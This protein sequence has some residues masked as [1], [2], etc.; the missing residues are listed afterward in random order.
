MDTLNK[1]LKYAPT[2]IINSK[3]ILSTAT[4]LELALIGQ[5]TDVKTE[6]ALKIKK[7]NSWENPTKHQQ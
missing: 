7:K 1:G 3:A 4:H 2:Q 6:F 5:P